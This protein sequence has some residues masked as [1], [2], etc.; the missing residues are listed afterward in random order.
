MT[1][2]NEVVFRGFDIEELRTVANVLAIVNKGR[3]DNVESTMLH[4]R[5]IT[6][7]NIEEGEPTYCSTLG[8]V[9]CGYWYCGNK[10][11]WRYKVSLAAWGV[12]KYLQR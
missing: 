1:S 6:V 9:A 4:I 11:D 12:D 2:V 8:F 10:D 3:C 5:D 7:A